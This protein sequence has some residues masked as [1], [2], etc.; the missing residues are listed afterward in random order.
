MSIDYQA[1]EVQY[2]KEVSQMPFK[3]ST[4]G[5]KTE[6]VS[7]L[8]RDTILVCINRSD[9]L[10]RPNSLMG[11]NKLLRILY[12]SRSRRTSIFHART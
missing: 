6:C 3:W 12:F 7:F 1:A 11:A 5:R 8:A 2:R 4:K 9:V 10:S